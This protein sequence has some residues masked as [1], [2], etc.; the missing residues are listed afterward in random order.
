[1]K[2]HRSLRTYGEAR[3]DDF[4]RIG[5]T[6]PLDFE[7]IFMRSSSDAMVANVLGSSR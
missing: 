7:E 6:P 4:A 2:G 1:M 3:F 5:P